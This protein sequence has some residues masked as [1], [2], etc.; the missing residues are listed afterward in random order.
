MFAILVTHAVEQGQADRSKTSAAT[1]T[2]LVDQNPI[3]GGGA[4]QLRDRVTD[5]QPIPGAHYPDIFV[6]LIIDLLPESNLDV[7]SG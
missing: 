6:G 5:A 4:F 3:T 7:I 1:K 2:R